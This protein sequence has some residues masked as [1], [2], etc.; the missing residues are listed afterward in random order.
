MREE[1]FGE[2]L[3]EKNRLLKEIFS[4]KGEIYDATSSDI[5]EL[6]ILI[7]LHLLKDT[8]ADMGFRYTC[9]ECKSVFP[10]YFYR[11]PKCQNISSAKVGIILTGKNHEE[12]SLIY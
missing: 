5:F 2:D 4:A 3:I 6:N 11:C 12:N 7:K 9:K 8:S 1:R 10:L